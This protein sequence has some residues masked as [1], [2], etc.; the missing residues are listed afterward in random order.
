MN[1]REKLIVI[2]VFLA[3]FGIGGDVYFKTEHF[4]LSAGA[5]VAIIILVMWW[6]YRRKK[7]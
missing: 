6:Y 4:E 1:F 7:K 3:V 5:G 2:G